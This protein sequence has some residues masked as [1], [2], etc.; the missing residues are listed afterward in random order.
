MEPCQVTDRE[1]WRGPGCA[2]AFPLRLAPDAGS[3][4]MGHGNHAKKSLRGG[5]RGLVGL[6]RSDE[7]FMDSAPIEPS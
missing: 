2:A 5:Q 7:G 1:G 4:R 6:T 3:P